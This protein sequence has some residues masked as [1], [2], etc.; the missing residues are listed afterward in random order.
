M[1][2][3]L[4]EIK[5][6]VKKGKGDYCCVKEPLLNI[7][8]HHVI[9]DELHLLLRVMDVMLN[10][11]ITKSLTGIRLKILKNHPKSLKASI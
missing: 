7:D 3:T 8:L 5:E 11:I 9:V 2:R 1:M 6:L 4:L 10:N